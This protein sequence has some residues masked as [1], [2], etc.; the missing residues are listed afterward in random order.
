[1]VIISF[2]L[3]YF[4]LIF[5]I[6]FFSLNSSYGCEYV[7]NADSCS[8]LEFYNCSEKKEVN[9][10]YGNLNRFNVRK[11]SNINNESIC[12]SLGVNIS[13]GIFPYWCELF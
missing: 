4:L 8:D 1:V 7:S 3:Y 9:Y 11:C 12:K 10:C 5:I 6:F 13:R 2:V